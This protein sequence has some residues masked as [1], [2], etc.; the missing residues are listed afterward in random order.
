[1]ALSPNVIAALQ[2][3]YTGRGVSAS[4]LNWWATDGANITYA[5]AVALFASSPDAAIKYPFFQAPQTADKRQYIAQVFANLYNIDIN[6]TSLVPTEELDYWIN[7]L[8]LSPDNYLDFPNALNNASAAAGLTDRLEALTNKADVS[9]SYTE[10]L[11]TAGVNTFT[12]AQYAEAAGIIAG[13]D[14]TPASVVAAEAE[15]AAIAAGL[16]VFTIAQAQATAN[17]PPLYTISDSA[18]NLIAGANDP[19]VAGAANV[20]ANESPAAPLDVDDANIL[21]ATANELAPGVTWDILDTAADVLAGGVAVSGAA[22]VGITDV[23]DVATASQLLALG[24][25]DGVYA[26]EDTSANIV[27]DTAVSGGA[28]AITLSDPEVPVSVAS[29]TFLQGLGIPVGPSYIVEDTSANILAAIGTPAIDNATEVIVSNTDAPLSVAQAEALLG[30]PNLDAGFTYILADTLE[31]LTDAPA[32]LLDGAVSYSL[33]NTNP[34]LGVIT[35]A[36]ADIV[37][38][39]TNAASFNFLVADVI[40]TPQADIVS[41]NSFLSVAVVEGGSIFNTLNSNDRLTGTG[42]D[43]TLSLTWQEATFGNINTIFPVLDGVETLVATL[44]ENDLTLVSNDFDV[45]G[46]GFITGLKNIAASGTKGGDLEIINLQTALET[47]SVTNYFFGDDVSF[48]IADPELVGDDDVLRLTVDQVT[49]D[50]GDVTSIKITDFSGTGGYETLG[51]TSGVTTSSK[52]NTNTVDIEGIIAVESIGITGIENLTLSTSLIGSVVKVDATGSAL[53]PE[54]EGNTVFTGDLKAF[55]DTPGGDINFLSGDGNDTIDIARDAETAGHTL[56]GGA[57]KD[58]LTITGDAFS[59]VDAGH[60]VIGGEGDDTILLTGVADG[61]IAGHVVNSFDLINEVGGGGNDTITITGDAI[62]NSAGHVVFGGTGEDTVRIEGDA[63]G[64]NDGGHDVFAGDDDDKVRITGNSFADA[65]GVSGHSVEGGTG[66][67]L[68]EI[69]G[70]AVIVPFG[71]EVAN[72]FFDPSRPT[73]P[74]VVIPVGQPLPTTQGQYEALLASLGIPNANPAF[75]DQAVGFGAHTVRGGEGNDRILFGPIAGEPGDGNGTHEAFGDEGNDFI[76]MTGKFGGVTFDG[77]A[78]DDTLVGG[79]GNDILSGGA[80]N[81]FLFG[82]QGNDTLTGGEGDDIL[83]GGQGDDFFDV[84]AGFDVVEDLGDSD[85]PTGDQFVVRPDA[86][87]EIRVVGD[88]VAVSP[89]T[90]N[91]GKATLTI[92]NPTGLLVDLSASN[93]AANTNGYTVIGNIGDDEIIGSRDNDTI[94]SGRGDDSIAGLGGDDIIEGNDDDDIISGDDLVINFDDGTDEQTSGIN[95]DDLIDAGSGN[96]LIAGDILVLSDVSN[97]SFGAPGLVNLQDGGDDTIE[98]GLGSDIAVGDW[99]AGVIGDIDLNGSLV[100]RTVRGGD[101]VITTK[102]GDNSIIFPVGQVAIDNFLVGD[103]LA[104]VDGDGSDIVADDFLT[105]IGGDDNITGADGLDVIVGDVGL[106]GFELGDSEIDLTNFKLGQVNGPT[107]TAGDDNIVGLGG[108]DILVGDLFVGVINNNGID[109]DGGNGFQ[110][111]GTTTFIGG[112][113]SI[114]GG[115]GNDFLAGDFVLVDQLSA[116]FNPLNPNDWTFVNPYATLQGQAGDSKAQAA[117]AAINLAQLR[118][119]FRAVGGDDELVGGSGNDTFY[120]G[121]GADTIEIGNDVTVGG[122]GINGQNEIWFMNGAFENAAV[123]GANVDNI[124]GFNVNN[125]KF[126][127]AAGANNFLSGD[128][129]SAFAVQ[130]VLNLQAGNTVFNLNDPI[131]NASANNINDVF[132]AVNADNSVGASLSVS[133]LPGLPSLVEMQQINVTSGALAGREF[134]FINN[135]VA[136]VSSQDDFL[137]ELTGISGTFGLDLTPNFEVREF[138]A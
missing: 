124:T 3:M 88:W 127:F 80:D 132:L 93:A 94:T 23:V 102:Q 70:D 58:A 30:L 44:I 116:P 119:E 4:D 45:V 21:L 92:Q 101:D 83:T 108:N 133:L 52:G 1:M 79:D 14:E 55:V 95:G 125:D 75:F 22:S 41:G 74:D 66:D 100:A 128:A 8:S 73:T 46:Q 19:V 106:F 25:F 71:Q 12:E 26:I 34:D 61:P 134:L 35:Q 51:L 126:V 105:V 103:L 28:T 104:L 48:S 53:I 13:V 110:L 40:L 118:L 96:D 33:T 85:A 2:I 9:L 98:A 24:N 129:T 15:V 135:G 138:Y 54:F 120:G 49:K 31:N 76:Q 67:D 137:V 121:L 131:L 27:A 42:E 115:D 62:G 86:E 17:L 50:V 56:S 16:S 5:E 10:A 37:N 65:G 130:R 69:S 84:D 64:V 18:D 77:G 63:D 43:P 36:E 20:I 32:A 107:V 123:N 112:D 57:G 60:T 89:V 38:G 78:G 6:D 82:N 136:A 91:Q 87:A 29:A 11:S 114:S 7:W 97:I 59:K 90:F 122:V 72:Q 113:D 111:G 109:I 117:Q 99:A 39:A 81:D 68:I 47:V